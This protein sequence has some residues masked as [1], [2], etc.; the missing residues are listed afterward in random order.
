MSAQVSSIVDRLWSAT[1]LR[2]C[3]WMA[4]AVAGG[5]VPAQDWRDDR[6]V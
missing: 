5:G 1:R 2:R 6:R 4:L 3:C